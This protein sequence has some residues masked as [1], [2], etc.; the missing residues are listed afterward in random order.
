MDLSEAHRADC[1]EAHKHIRR[2]IDM[3]ESALVVVV[4]HTKFE[5]SEVVNIDHIGDASAFARTLASRTEP[6]TKGN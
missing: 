5:T 4:K 2:L 3:L 6:T 1:V